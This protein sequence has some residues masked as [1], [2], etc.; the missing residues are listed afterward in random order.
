MPVSV[1]LPREALITFCRRWY[2]VE[3]S[4]FGSIL[5]D[6]FDAQTSDIDIIVDFAPGHTPGL[7]AMRMQ[8]ELE[9]LL[10]RRVDLLTREGIAHTGN[11]RLRREIMQSAERYYAA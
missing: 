5:R 11:A 10:G 7:A 3:L 6:D 4:F 1:D 9:S 8:G 2:I